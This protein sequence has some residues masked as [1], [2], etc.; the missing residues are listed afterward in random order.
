MADVDRE[1]ARQQLK[2]SH[3]A[4][5]EE[6]RVTRSAHEDGVHPLHCPANANTEA[7]ARSCTWA[8]VSKSK[9]SP[10]T[11]RGEGVPRRVAHYDTYLLIVYRKHYRCHASPVLRAV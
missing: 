5:T 3:E 6:L 4:A 11:A 1:A 8:D 7:Y 9:K 10:L 2:A